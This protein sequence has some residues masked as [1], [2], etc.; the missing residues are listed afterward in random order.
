[1]MCPSSFALFDS[2]IGNEKMYPGI[3]FKILSILTPRN[4]RIIPLE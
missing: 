1:M 2:K 4:I 3:K